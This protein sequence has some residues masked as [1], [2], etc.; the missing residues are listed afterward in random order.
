[1]LSG[2]KKLYSASGKIALLEATLIALTDVI[3]GQILRSIS[4][5]ENL[6]FVL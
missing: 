1:M 2:T 4:D 6:G 5:A 3:R